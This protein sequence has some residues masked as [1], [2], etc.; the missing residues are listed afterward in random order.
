M[1][2]ERWTKCPVTVEAV[3]YLRGRNEREI[4]EFCRG[5]DAACKDAVGDTHIID[6][7]ESLELTEFF[8]IETLEGDMELHDGSWLIRGIKG[9]FYP[10][11]DD[12]FREIYETESADASE[13]Y[14][15]VPYEQF[16]P[17]SYAGVREVMRHPAS[18]CE[19]ALCKHIL[20][21][22]TRCNRLSEIVDAYRERA[23]QI[24]AG[25]VFP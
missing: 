1:S 5:A 16:E 3:Q 7:D 17:L 6:H 18:R 13:P 20:D 9:E 8:V 24:G 2:V 11:R 15:P 19:Q 25:E 10:C 21:L 12:I 22:E 4:V 14:R 23:A